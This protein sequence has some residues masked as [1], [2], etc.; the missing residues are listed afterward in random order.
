MRIPDGVFF[1]FLGFAL[2]ASGL[3]LIR[4]TGTAGP[5]IAGVCLIVL[6]LEELINEA[7]TRRG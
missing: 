1:R 5:Q 3:L 7:I 2:L 4:W 6:G